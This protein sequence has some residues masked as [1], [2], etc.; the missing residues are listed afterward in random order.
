M[1]Y[2]DKDKVLED[3]CLQML[4]LVSAGVALIVIVCCFLP[5]FL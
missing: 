2:D 5:D 3:F 4:L 1:K